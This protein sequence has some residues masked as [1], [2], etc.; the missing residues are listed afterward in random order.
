M[1]AAFFEPEAE[2][3]LEVQTVYLDRCYFVFLRMQY[4][5]NTG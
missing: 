3:V 5:K 1:L 2:K 4:G